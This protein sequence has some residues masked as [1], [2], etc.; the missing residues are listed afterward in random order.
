MNRVPRAKLTRLAFIIVPLGLLAAWWR[1]TRPTPP[2]SPVFDPILKPYVPAPLARWPLPG[3]KQD[4]PNPGVTHWFARDAS[5]TTVD[6]LDFDFQL[7]PNLRWSLYDQDEA[8][9]KPFD[10]HTLYKPLGVAK[11][12]QEFDAGSLPRPRGTIVAAWNGAFF[13]YRDKPAMDN[14]FHVSP[15]VINGK[16]FFTKNNHRWTFGVKYDKSGRPTW[17]VLFKPSVS[18][19]EQEFDWAAGA[20]QCLI[21]EGKPLKLEPFPKN[22]SEIKRRTQPSTNQEAGHIPHFDHMR[23]CRASIAWSRDNRHLYLLSVK[24][25]DDELS[26]SL[27]ASHGTPDPGGFT[28]QDVQRFWLQKGVWGAINSDAGNV[29]QLVFRLPDGS[30]TVIPSKQTSPIMRITCPP[31]WK[32]A[33]PAGGAL[34]YFYVWQK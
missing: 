17:K 31:N 21:K 6:V 14:A 11:F 9:D 27:A 12:A 13:G 23:T 19:L 24:E 34:M 10:D 26:S 28:V 8:D 25:P 32:G 3:A 30:H 5:G 33:P 1:T 18:Q 4:R 22:H 16:A 20:L 15:V 7:N 29:G 2:P